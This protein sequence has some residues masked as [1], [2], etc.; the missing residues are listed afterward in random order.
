MDGTKERWRLSN[1]VKGRACRE[2]CRDGACKTKRD[3][4]RGKRK[5]R[6]KRGIEAINKKVHNAGQSGSLPPLFFF[7]SF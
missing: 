3:E 6:D 4:V 2:D 1:P 7:P 5:D